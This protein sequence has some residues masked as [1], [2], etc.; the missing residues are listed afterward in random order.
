MGGS[1]VKKSPV[2][3]PR[4]LPVS[5]VFKLLI[6]R[7]HKVAWLGFG[8]G[9]VFF[10]AFGM[11]ADITAPFVFR[12]VFDSVSGVVVSVDDTAASE[13]G[14]DDDDGTPILAYRYRFKHEGRTFE[15]ISYQLSD[16]S[17]LGA[18]DP[19]TVVFPPSNP[20]TSRI[21]GMR[22][23]IFE[24]YMFGVI[25]FLQYTQPSYQLV[26]FWFLR[27]CL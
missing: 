1:R 10:W 24:A 26:W 3:Q 27:A 21:S 13:G 25:I 7:N 18:G 15:G 4:S 8:I 20:G 5:L 16:E 14:Y 2:R 19:V 11:N 9:M 23:A 17:K 12:G 22:S 6:G